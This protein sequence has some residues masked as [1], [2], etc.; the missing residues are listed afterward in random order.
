MAPQAPERGVTP[1]KS[2]SDSNANE[3]HI[4]TLQEDHE[5]KA[6][7]YAA[8][9]R[10]VKPPSRPATSFPD[11]KE[12]AERTVASAFSVAAIMF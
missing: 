6:R 10:G 8:Y 4:A 2:N 12:E 1:C 5:D 3:F 11:T 9:L 7:E